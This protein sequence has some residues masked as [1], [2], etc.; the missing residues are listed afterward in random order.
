MEPSFEMLEDFLESLA[1]DFDEVISMYNKLLD[2]EEIRPSKFHHILVL[3][4]GIKE[5][6]RKNYLTG[7]YTLNQQISENAVRCYEMAEIAYNEVLT[8]YSNLINCYKNHNL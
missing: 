6:I 7:K 2:A 5:N 3:M 8:F 1:E 4:F